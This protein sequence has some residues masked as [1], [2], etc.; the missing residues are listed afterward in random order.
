MSRRGRLEHRQQQPRNGRCQPGRAYRHAQHEHQQ[1]H[2]Q[3]ER[4]AAH[5]PGDQDAQLVLQPEHVAQIVYR[6]GQ[7]GQRRRQPEPGGQQDL[8]L[9]DQH[10]QVCRT[11]RR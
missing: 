6:A 10:Q 3:R 7:L 9:H 4:N 2:D 5:Q 11:C 8:Q 1:Q